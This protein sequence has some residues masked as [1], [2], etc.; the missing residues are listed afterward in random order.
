MMSGS[1]FLLLLGVLLWALTYPLSFFEALKPIL[2]IYGSVF[3][4]FFFIL[5]CIVI[6]V[7]LS[8]RFPSWGRRDNWDYDADGNP[9][10]KSQP[11]NWEDFYRDHR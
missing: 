7:E 6:D 3:G 4:I 8:A 11:D 1:Q 2:I 5:L 9:L 10:D